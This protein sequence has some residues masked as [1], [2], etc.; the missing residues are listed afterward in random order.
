MPAGDTQTVET[1]PNN[2]K[3]YD[4]LISKTAAGKTEEMAEVS[5]RLVEVRGEG[6]LL[7]YIWKHSG[8]KVVSLRFGEHKLVEIEAPEGYG[9]AAPIEFSVTKDGKVL[10]DGKEVPKKSFGG[11]EYPVVHMENKL[12]EY[13]ISVS[14]QV[15]W[16]I[17]L[18]RCI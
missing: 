8:L 4:L 11:V 1:I 2:R 9:I 5:L 12:K 15:I 6:E 14:E 7:E 17:E 3:R 16:E 10:I 18:A 13:E